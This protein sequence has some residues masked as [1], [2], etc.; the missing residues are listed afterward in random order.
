MGKLVFLKQ[1]AAV[2]D[3]LLN[4]ARVGFKHRLA[5]QIARLGGES[6]FGST[7]AITGSP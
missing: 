3:Q 5:L 1:R 4:N 6:T 2:I 7:G